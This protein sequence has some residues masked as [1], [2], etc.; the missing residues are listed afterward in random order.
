VGR[1]VPASAIH[2]GISKAITASAGEGGVINI[3][4]SLWASDAMEKTIADV[5]F[6][7][8][9]L[10]SSMPRFVARLLEMSTQALASNL[11]LVISAGNGVL[12]ENREFQGFDVCQTAPKKPR[13]VSRPDLPLVMVGATD[14]TDALAVF[15]NFGSCVDLFG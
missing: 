7:L 3:S 4:Y 2:A 9:L 8:P 13:V 14:S 5:R 15:S 10:C 11:H 12:G 6:G 1:G